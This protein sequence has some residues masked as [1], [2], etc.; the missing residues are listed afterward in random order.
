[1]PDPGTDPGTAPQQPPAAPTNYD[2][3]GTGTPGATVTLG[4]AGLLYGTT[5][6]APNG[7]WALHASS[8][9]GDGG[10]QPDGLQLKQTVAVPTTKDGAQTDGTSSPLTVQSGTDGI[11]FEVI[12]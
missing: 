12:G 6:V 2:L 5:T 1:V 3:S 11:V 8:A 10:A 4:R 7:T 9:S